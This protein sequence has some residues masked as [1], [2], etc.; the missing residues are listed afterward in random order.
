[1]LKNASTVLF[2]ICYLPSSYS[3]LLSFVISPRPSLHASQFGLLSLSPALSLS[4]FLEP[5]D[6]REEARAQS[7]SHCSR[8]P[9]QHGPSYLQPPTAHCYTCYFFLSHILRYFQSFYIHFAKILFV[10]V[11]FTPPNQLGTN[12]PQIAS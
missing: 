6:N 5:A 7:E 10:F 8:R 12:I 3:L 11:A 4:L 9:T 1:M 2:S